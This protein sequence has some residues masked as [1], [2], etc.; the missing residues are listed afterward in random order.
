MAKNVTGSAAANILSAFSENAAQ[1]HIM[2]ILVHLIV[3]HPDN[4]ASRHDTDESIRELADNIRVNGLLHPLVVRKLA[5]GTY[6]L[7]SGERRYRAITT[8]LDWKTIP[9]TVYENISDA[10]EKIM[11]ISANLETRRYS[12][13][14]LL[15]L[16]TEYDTA[17]RQLKEEG[18]YKGGIQKGIAVL[19]GVSERQIRNYRAEVEA[20]KGMRNSPSAKVEKA[21]MISA[22]SDDELIELLQCVYN[23]QKVIEFYQSNMPT[24][25]EAVAFL[26]P[27]T[28][29]HGATLLHNGKQGQWTKTNPKL[30]IR[31][32]GRRQ[33]LK[34]TEVDRLIRLAIATKKWKITSPN[35]K[36]TSTT[37]VWEQW[38]DQ[39]DD[40]LDRAVEDLV[41]DR[42]S[43]NA[44]KWFT[45]DNHFFASL[46]QALDRLIKKS[47]G[48]L[49]DDADQYD[50]VSIFAEK[51]AE[52]LLT[53][54][55]EIYI[56]SLAGDEEL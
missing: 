25:K 50:R 33:E 54:E 53:L 11:L 3:L 38:R 47:C 20:Q 45:I 23:K 37:D 9:C 41:E 40:M 18:A 22:F 14:D 2:D 39:R 1:S 46:E 49:M 16:Y 8:Y 52:D 10:E 7:I 28:G 21:E 19:M 51:L 42:P 55:S 32:D 24:T 12:K 17:L 48:R 35:G 43:D 36:E 4:T 26:K 5:D 6:R 15:Q 31:F 30:E 56:N 44:D 29:Y 13:E 27:S 34:Y